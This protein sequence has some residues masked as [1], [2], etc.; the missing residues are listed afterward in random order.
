ML[1]RLSGSWMFGFLG[2]TP[3]NWPVTSGSILVTEFLVG[4]PARMRGVPLQI[5]RSDGTGN[6]DVFSCEAGEEIMLITAFVNLNKVALRSFNYITRSR[7]YETSD[8]EVSRS[9]N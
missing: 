7:S 1:A 5:S 4:V 2:P 3:T 9:C 8:P 6:S